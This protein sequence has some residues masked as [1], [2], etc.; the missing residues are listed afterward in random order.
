MANTYD[1]ISGSTIS[2]DT[3][4]VTFSNISAS[5]TDLVMKISARTTN[6]S[7]GTQF[8]FDLN[9]SSTAGSY[10]ILY[11]DGSTAATS[12]LT[13]ASNFVPIAELALPGAA[14]TANI[15]SNLEIYIPS[16]TSSVRKQMNVMNANENNNANSWVMMGAVKWTGTAA[17]SSILMYPS[18][19]NFVAQSSFY[20]YGIKNT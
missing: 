10:R 4:S 14:S 9:A 3:A 8:R 17:I 11:S 12:G 19:G 5:Y 15:F 18:S 16:Y 7:T 6:N 2:V 13:T 20:L 1:L